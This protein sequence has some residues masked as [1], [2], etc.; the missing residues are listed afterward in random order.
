MAV[1]THV[2]LRGVTKEQYDAVREACDWLA[3]TPKGGHAHLTYFDGD[4]CHSWDA[5]ESED[6]F[7]AFG[8]TRLGPAMAKVGVEAVPEVAFFAAHEVFTP[9]VQR[10]TAT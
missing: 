6:A 10:L 4:E 8:E 7:A 9:A 3:D 2:L 5:W 1:I